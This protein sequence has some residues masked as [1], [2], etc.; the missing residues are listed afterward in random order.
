MRLRMLVGLTFVALPIAAGCSGPQVESVSA[1]IEGIDLKGVDLVFDIDV[2]NPYPVAIRP[3]KNHYVVDIAGAD[4]LKG[5]GSADSELPA[6][7]LGTISLPA[8]LEYSKM[9]QAYQNLRE[10]REVPYKLHGALVFTVSER[11]FEVPYSL[12]GRLPVLRPPTLAVTHVRKTDASLSRAA[13]EIEAEITNPN[14]FELGI[15]GV[16]YSVR[17]GEVSVGG[18]AASTGGTV[19]AGASG[20]LVLAGEVTGITALRQLVSGK[21]PGNAVIVATG[22]IKTPY[23]TVALPQ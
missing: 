20:K 18:I 22:E 8:R 12:D 17:L 6:R 2:R 9:W 13:V 14:V 10:S 7:G 3:P 16:G 11:E 1:R 5:D 19:A 4:F 15:E 21:R 23:G